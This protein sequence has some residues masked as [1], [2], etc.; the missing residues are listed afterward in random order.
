VTGLAAYVVLDGHDRLLAASLEGASAPA[1]CLEAI[2]DE[3]FV[4][5]P[6]ATNALLEG[7]AVSW[8]AAERERARPPAER[9][10]RVRR[11]LDV[12]R[13]NHLLLDAFVPELGTRP[14]Q[15]RRIP[16]GIDQWLRE[17]GAEL[18]A[19]GI[20]DTDLLDG[21]ETRNQKTLAG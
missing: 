10:A 19:Q 11:L 15:A 4:R 18:A 1:L 16:G 5:D 7:L 13:A 17:V 12:D 6:A 9:L 3:A 20:R 14:T 8:A 2:S 21:L